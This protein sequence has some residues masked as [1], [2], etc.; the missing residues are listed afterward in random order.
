MSS[1]ALN[2]PAPLDERVG[3]VETKRSSYPVNM[4]VRRPGPGAL[5]VQRGQVLARAFS[6]ERESRRLQTRA[7]QRNEVEGRATCAWTGRRGA[8]G[9]KTPRPCIESP[10][11]EGYSGRRSG[12]LL[13]V[14]AC[15]ADDLLTVG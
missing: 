5:L 6:I 1:R 4:V 8:C 10:L 12:H 2:R 11:L 7:L 9:L 14:S 15:S 3:L 13:T